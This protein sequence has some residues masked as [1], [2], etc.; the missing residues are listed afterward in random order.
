[1]NKLFLALV[2]AF[3]ISFF[4][5]LSAVAQND[6]EGK[7]LISEKPD[8]SI[9]KFGANR[10][11]YL[12]YVA[13]IGLYVDQ[14]EGNIDVRTGFDFQYKFLYKRKLTKVLAIGT[15]LCY[16]YQNFVLNQ[17][18]NVTYFEQ[19]FWNNQNVNHRK[20]RFYQHNIQS[21]IFLR[22]NFDPKRGNTLGKYI[23]IAGYGEY[24]LGSRYQVYDNI[25]NGLREKRTFSKLNITNPFNY[26]ISARVAVFDFLLV[27]VSYRYSDLFKS[28]S[29]VP[30]MPRTLAQIYLNINN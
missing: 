12:Q 9:A 17:N 27:G 11:H 15:G 13:L 14:A 30:E 18:D 2:F 29:T 19:Y 5:S 21:E 23:D 24:R 20:E 25:A 28:N 7:E 10:R 1:M 8:S 26:G 6:E 16:H 3:T 22:I 4:S